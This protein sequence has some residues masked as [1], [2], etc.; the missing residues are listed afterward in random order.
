MPAAHPHTTNI[1]SRDYYEWEAEKMEEDP[2]YIWFDFMNTFTKNNVVDYK[3]EREECHDLRNVHQHRVY[4]SSR[5]QKKFEIDFCAWAHAIDTHCQNY[6]TCYTTKNGLYEQ[7]K[8]TVQG[9]EAQFKK[10]Q[11]AL[12]CALCYGEQLLKDSTNLT[13][14]DRA[15]GCQ[16]CEPLNIEYPEV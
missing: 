7:Q 9:E 1:V 3:Q 4:D 6:D 14:C 13:A 5:K 15:D 8:T 10:Q 16:N 11:A 2:V 12:E